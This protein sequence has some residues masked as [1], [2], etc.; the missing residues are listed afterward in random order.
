MGTFSL[1]KTNYSVIVRIH[2]HMDFY[3]GKQVLG[4]IQ[5]LVLLQQIKLEVLCVA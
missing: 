4:H 1:T 2:K 5:D 3:L